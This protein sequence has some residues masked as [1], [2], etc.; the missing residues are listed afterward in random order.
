VR[1][2]EVLKNGDSFQPSGGVEGHG[3]GQNVASK[4]WWAGVR[5]ERMLKSGKAD[6]RFSLLPTRFSLLF[7]RFCR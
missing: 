3:T 5:N 2:E 1:N 7:T 4:R 6:T